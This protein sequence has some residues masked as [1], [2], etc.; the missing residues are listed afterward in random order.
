M[1]LFEIF[2]FIWPLSVCLSV[3][4]LASYT[5]SFWQSCSDIQVPL[6]ISLLCCFNSQTV[7]ELNFN[8]RCIPFTGNFRHFFFVCIL[9]EN[10]LSL[11]IMCM[12]ECGFMHLSTVPIKVTRGSWIL[13]NW[14]Y[15]L[16]WATQY[17][18]EILYTCIG[19]EL[20]FSVRVVCIIDH[21]DIFLTLLLAAS[22]L[23]GVGL[24]LICGDP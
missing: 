22:M 4:Q 19:H 7:R 6:L 23:A 20:T 17:R 2:T 5:I 18:C 24:W 10:I 3:L 1:L 15:S 12:L 9:S 14:S 8:D 16:L 21:C 11:I 13:K